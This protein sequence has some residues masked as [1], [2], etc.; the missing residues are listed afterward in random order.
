MP[1]EFSQNLINETIQCFKEEDN[2]NITSEQATEY[3]NGM[4]DLYLAFTNFDISDP[5]L[6]RGDEMSKKLTTNNNEDK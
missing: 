6:K 4:A 2:L 1:F 3:L 5:S